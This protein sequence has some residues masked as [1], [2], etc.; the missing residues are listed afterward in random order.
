MPLQPHSTTIQ[1]LEGALDT[2]VNTTDTVLPSIELRLQE[3]TQKLMQFL[4]YC[5]SAMVDVVGA[6]S[7]GT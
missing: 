1:Y 5:H 2:M 7:M 6:P 4:K 3:S